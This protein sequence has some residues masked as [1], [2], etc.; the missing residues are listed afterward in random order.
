MSFA[1]WEIFSITSKN[2]AIFSGDMPSS[3]SFESRFSISWY[4]QTTSSP[5]SVILNRFSRLSSGF[6]VRL[7]NPFSSS[8]SIIRITTDLFLPVAMAIFCRIWSVLAFIMF[9]RMNSSTVILTSAS[10]V[11][12]CFINRC[13]LF[14]NL[15]TVVPSNSC[16][17]FF[18]FDGKDSII[19][20][21]SCYCVLIFGG[22]GI[23]FMYLVDPW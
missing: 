4:W 20:C 22:Y 1:F 6:T 12:H 15:P 11:Y 14:R 2:V 17:M 9:S 13:S 3:N 5:F 10:C 8:E 19:F 21:I 18:Y 23:V 7:A 16:V